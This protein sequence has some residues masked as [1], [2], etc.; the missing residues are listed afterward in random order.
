[1][2]AQ[3]KEGPGEVQ[4]GTLSWHMPVHQNQHIGYLDLH[5][6]DSEVSLSLT[7]P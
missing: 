6:A 4:H 3:Q 7:V 2:E 1:M 5:T